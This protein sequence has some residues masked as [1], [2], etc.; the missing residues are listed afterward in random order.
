[1]NLNY[2]N[3]LPG[4]SIVSAGLVLLGTTTNVFAAIG[5]KDTDL[6]TYDKS[7]A[8][9]SVAQ[10]VYKAKNTDKISEEID[11]NLG[12]Y[13]TNEEINRLISKELS[14]P[15]KNKNALKS[16]STNRKLGDTYDNRLNYEDSDD[17][18]V[19]TV[20]AENLAVNNSAETSLADDAD[21][22]NSMANLEREKQVQNNNIN[23]DIDINEYNKA[24]QNESTP[25]DYNKPLSDPNYY[26]K[27]ERERLSQYQDQWAEIDKLYGR[28][29]STAA[30]MRP[31]REDS[32]QNVEKYTGDSTNSNPYNVTPGHILE[33]SIYNPTGL[34]AEQFESLLVG[35]G[36]EGLG[37]AF[38]DMENKWGVDGLFCMA[39]GFHESAKGTSRL[40]VNN[41]NLFGM[42][43]KSGWKKFNSKYENILYFGEY[44]NKKLYKGKTTR[45]IGHIYCPPNTD[46]WF[47]CVNKYYQGFLSKVE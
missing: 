34:S 1:M 38:V 7:V 2:K 28:D 35:T 8:N 22:I 16:F 27:K 9:K 14:N 6:C 4:I 43:S 36:M 29:G 31:S 12:E 39:V 30:A 19:E 3:I 13:K 10:E 46:H 42:R 20:D 23:T 44:M 40:A 33:R 41:N 32:L 25:I 21:V 45:E 24:R 37:Q 15:T 5:N 18:Q 26:V 47:E 11:K 17:D